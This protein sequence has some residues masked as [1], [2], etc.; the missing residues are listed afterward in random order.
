[1]SDFPAEPLLLDPAFSPRPWGGTKLKEKFGK[2]P[3]AGLGPIGE[4]WELS[5]HPNG[6]S[7]VLGGA[8]AGREFGEVLRAFPREMIGREAA[9]ER[10]PLL[11]KLIDAAEDLSIQVHPQDATAPAGERGKTECWYVMDC[12]PGTEVVFGLEME[13]A[14]EDVLRGAEDGSLAEHVRRFR[15]QPGSFLF[16]RAGTVHGILG[17][18][19]ICEVQQSSDTTYRLWDWNREPK[20]ELHVEEALKVVDWNACG[21][22]PTRAPELGTAAGEGIVM[23]DCEFFRV[24]VLDVPAGGEAELPADVVDSGLILFGLQGATELRWAEGRAELLRGATAFVPAVCGRG[25]RLGNGQ[26]EAV[27]V[28]LAESREL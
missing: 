21:S 17:G 8:F 22:L 2:T 6:R 15:I 10:Y 24:R 16:V 20:R 18:T 14:P 1:M 7:R 19:V 9:P 13:V 3:P 26:G 4:S 25:V 28:L 5:D 11:V 27:R 23:A 12:E